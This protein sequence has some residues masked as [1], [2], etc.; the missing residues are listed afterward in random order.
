MMTYYKYN[1]GFGLPPNHLVDEKQ[2]L[3]C[4][5][6]GI[7]REM[8]D[9]DD[10]VF[11]YGNLGGDEDVIET[12]TTY[13]TKNTKC[14]YD[15]KNVMITFGASSGILLTA[16][17]LLNPGDN[18][19][20]EFPTFFIASE[21]YKNLKVNLFPAK[22]TEK[23]SFNFDEL[24]ESII[25]NNIKGFYLVTNFNNPLGTNLCLN[26]RAK[27]YALANKHKIYI[28]SDDIYELMYY[29][30]EDRVTPIYFCN[31]ETIEKSD[32]NEKLMKFNND[33]SPYIIS[34]NS[35][36]KVIC[37][38]I[39]FGFIQAHTDIIKKLHYNSVNYSMCGFKSITQHAVRSFILKGYMDTW[40]EKQRDFI[41]KNIQIGIDSLSKCNHVEFNKP[42]GGYFIFVKLKDYV[43]DKKFFEDRE[44]NNFNFINGILTVPS[45]MRKDYPEYEKYVRLSFSCI[46]HDLTRE[47]MDA[48]IN[49]I[50]SCIDK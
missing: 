49:Y 45:E 38:S 7:S 34:I 3:E 41:R 23:G 26:D 29:K 16:L 4:F 10:R 12:L 35:F 2:L 32:T 14:F 46:D 24:E 18:I 25:K 19:L 28:F 17:T 37:P 47:A 1:L 21:I 5:Q 11:N 6:E 31:E 8:E 36:N 22:R 39:K 50:D 20:C 43:N 48:L 9:K 40:V 42:E 13:Y 44:K 30:E 27:I 33:T 15:P